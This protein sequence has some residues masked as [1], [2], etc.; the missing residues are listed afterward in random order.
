MELYERDTQ[1][2]FI[3]PEKGRKNVLKAIV[4]LESQG[5]IREDNA[6][7][8]LVTKKGWLIAE[9][10]VEGYFDLDKIREQ[11]IYYIDDVSSKKENEEEESGDKG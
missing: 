8:V 6:G 9:G 11:G 5:L 7:N 3:I 10:L 2:N 4:K 1:R